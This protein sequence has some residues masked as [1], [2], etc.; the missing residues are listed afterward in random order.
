MKEN[1]RIIVSMLWF[2]I[3]VFTFYSIVSS[4]AIFI[5]FELGGDVFI[6]DMLLDRFPNYKL[7]DNIWIIIF[8]TVHAILNWYIVYILFVLKRAFSSGEP[9][10]FTKLQT[11]QLKTGGNGLITYALLNYMLWSISGLLFF[12]SPLVVLQVFLPFLIVYM[13]GRLALVISYM[14]E[15]GTFL[16]EETDL[17]I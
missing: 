4:V 17:T 14:T 9:A 15:K 6:R 11:L 12:H 10:L 13:L 3:I 8:L 7:S 2:L 16:K 5:N 1:V